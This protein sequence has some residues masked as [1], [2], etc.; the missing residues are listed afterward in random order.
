MSNSNYYNAVWEG[1][2]FPTTEQLQG[3]FEVDIVTGLFRAITPFARQWEKR[4]TSNIGW[5]TINDKVTGKFDIVHDEICPEA[6]SEVNP[7]LMGGTFLDYRED[8]TPWYWGRLRDEMRTVTKNYH[9]GKIWFRMQEN[10]KFMG[11]FLLT[12][13]KEE[14]YLDRIT[15]WSVLDTPGLVKFLQAWWVTTEYSYIKIDSDILS[16]CAGNVKGN[17]RILD[18]LQRNIYVWSRRHFYTS[19]IHAYDEYRLHINLLS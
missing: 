13:I 5:N 9:I 10:Y 11:F 8:Q 15:N 4:I 12:D 14:F 1:A 7:E 17:R 3:H 6:G 2:S 18:A 16:I 19:D